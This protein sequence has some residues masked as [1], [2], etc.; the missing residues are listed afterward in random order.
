MASYDIF[1]KILKNLKKMFILNCLVQKKRNN[2][3]KILELHQK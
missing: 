2:H 3:F 1:F